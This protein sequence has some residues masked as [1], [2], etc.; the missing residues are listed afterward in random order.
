[1]IFLHKKYVF[2]TI[3][4]LYSSCYN[5]HK[6]S[7]YKIVLQNGWFSYEKKYYPQSD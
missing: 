1:M 7:F 5:V 4:V 3:E 2:Y 6:L